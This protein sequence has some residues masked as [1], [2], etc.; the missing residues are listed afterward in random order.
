MDDTSREPGAAAPSAGGFPRSD[1]DERPASHLKLAMRRARV[2]EAE[3]SDVIAEL[4]G[5][6]IARLEMLQDALVP[7]LTDVPGDID[8]FDVGIMP[9]QHPRLFIDM[10]GFVEMGRDRRVYRFVQDTRHGRLVM[11]ESE[12]IEKMV[13]AV[14]DYMARRLLE[15]EKALA[16][17]PTIERAARAFEAR[18]AAA[19]AA[20]ARPP[21]APPARRFGRLR[22]TVMFVIDLLGT[23]ALVGLIAFGSWYLLARI[24]AR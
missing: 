18:K 14:T 21:A 22:S 16:A 12:R 9:G 23:A 24:L 7:V 5:A 20:R 4:R 10:I 15:R 19:V 17:D 1:A 6:E 2:D 11:A 8:I 13:E 3:R